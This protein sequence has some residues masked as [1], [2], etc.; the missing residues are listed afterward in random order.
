[1][2]AGAE[3]EQ[4][5]SQTV[6]AGMTTLADQQR[7]EAERQAAEAAESAALYRSHMDETQRQLDAVREQKV[8]PNRLLY[9]DGQK[10]MALIGGL[11]GGLYQGLNKLQSNPF[12]DDLNRSIDR[13]IAL[14]KE[15]LS[16]SERSIEGRQSLLGQM[17]SVYKDESLATAQAKNLYYEGIKQQ[18]AA[19]AATFDSP[20][21]QAKADQGIAVI[22][23]AQDGL[24]LDEASR[25]AAAAQAAAGAA[26]AA[27]AKQQQQEFENS[28]KVYEAGT[29]RLAATKDAGKAQSELRTRMV[30]TGKDPETGEPTGYLARN[31]E[32]AA[33]R[34][35]SRTAAQQL[36]SKIDRAIEIRNEQGALG[37]SVN[38]GGV[39]NFLYTPEWQSQLKSLSN[40]MLVDWKQA[41]QLGALDKG[42]QEIG[43]EVIG[44]LTSIGS[45]SEERLLELKRSLERGLKVEDEQAAGVRV[46]MRADESV[47]P[48]GGTNAPSNSRTGSR[49]R[50]EAP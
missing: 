42:A 13:D 23:R 24:K 44:D 9:D 30:A 22:A 28:L 3:I 49:V 4:A 10:A 32:E 40:Q 8:D 48:I 19:Q 11:L 12:L 46:R 16:R 15:D 1:M 45:R 38:T 47:E 50:R 17:R 7:M 39:G 20:A 36:L 14:Q 26:A 25:N 33:K 6:A 27:R 31:P 18:L 2:R 41:G 37:R 35:T 5:R 34:E 43:G 21:I 29:H